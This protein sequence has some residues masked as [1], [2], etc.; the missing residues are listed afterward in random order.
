MNT[1]VRSESCVPAAS[2]VITASTV[3]A[4]ALVM[5]VARRKSVNRTA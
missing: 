3:A 2:T 5:T 1:T 4:P